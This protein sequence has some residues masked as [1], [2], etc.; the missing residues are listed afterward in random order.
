M[1]ALSCSNLENSHAFY[2]L[3]ISQ[4]LDQIFSLLTNSK[5]LTFFLND[6][7]KGKRYLLLHHH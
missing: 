3:G 6:T 7:Y 1:P 5:Y 2:L 4:L